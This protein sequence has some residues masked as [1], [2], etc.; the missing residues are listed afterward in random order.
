M[1]TLL[2]ERG[3]LGFALAVAGRVA[4]DELV[5]HAKATMVNGRSAIEDA[6]VRQRIAKLHEEVEANLLNNYRAL[7]GIMKTGV[8]GP[9]G[10]LSKLMFSET[11]QEIARLGI[12]IEGS[13]GLL[14]GGSPLSPQNGRWQYGLL[15]SRGTTIE[16]GTSEILRNIVAER[17]LGLPKHK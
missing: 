7:S 14:E 6:S 16:A 10:S 9:E 4:L 12:E 11:L 3:T 13:Y 2:H 5:Q 8:P 17:V 1:T 15:R